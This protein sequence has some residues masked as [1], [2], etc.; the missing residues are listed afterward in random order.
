M[1]EYI[2][3][4]KPFLDQLGALGWKI[5]NQRRGMIPSDPAKSLRSRF[6]KSIL[7]GSLQY[8]MHNQRLTTPTSNAKIGA[9]SYVPGGERCP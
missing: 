8:S 3:V 6:R 7:P 2:H 9:W 1:S 5:V 4:E